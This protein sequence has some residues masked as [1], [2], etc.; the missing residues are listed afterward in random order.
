MMLI[1]I[2]IIVPHPHSS[3]GLSHFLHVPQEGTSTAAIN[4]WRFL[5]ALMCPSI[6]DPLLPPISPSPAL[7]LQVGASMALLHLQT[8]TQM[9]VDK[10]RIYVIMKTYGHIHF[11][12]TEMFSLFFSMFRST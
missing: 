3:P 12:W 5:S 6:H 4:Y 7:R 9:R 2:I 8:T 11:L 1:I 10:S